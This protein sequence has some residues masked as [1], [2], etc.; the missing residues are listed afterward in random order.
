MKLRNLV[1]LCEHDLFDRHVVEL[2]H[3][4]AMGE[5]AVVCPGGVFLP[6]DT[7]IIEGGSASEPFEITDME[8]RF[9]IV[10]LPDDT[11]VF[12]PEDCETCGGTGS[13]T[14]PAASEREHLEGLRQD[15]CPRCRNGK[16][17]PALEAFM[18]W[19]SLDALSVRDHE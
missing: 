6:D 2:G 16:V 4:P 18:A 13:V 3:P 12:E 5:T 7:L 9:V 14:H 11:L 19:P 1:R 10:R 8:G 17:Y 15:Q